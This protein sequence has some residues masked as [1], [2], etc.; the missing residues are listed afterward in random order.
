[1]RPGSSPPEE[2]DFDRR[3]SAGAYRL[4]AL[5]DKGEKYRLIEEY[6]PECYRETPDGLLLEREF[7]SR[8]NM[9][10]WVLSFGGR[11]EVLE[12]DELRT[13]LLRQAEAM[14]KKYRGT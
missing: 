9:R 10:E 2:M 8:S 6:G 4:K 7:A 3:F 5:F 13:D 12:P 14:A 1:M 11:A